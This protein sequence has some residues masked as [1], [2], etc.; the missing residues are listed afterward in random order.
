MHPA[1]FKLFWIRNR[2][3]FRRAIRGARTLRGAVLLLV[4]LGVVGLWVGMTLFMTL[5]LLRQPEAAQVTARY[6]GSAEPYL[7]LILLWLCLTN[8]LQSSG[9]VFLH[10]SP[11]EVEF[12]FPGPFHRRELL[13]FKL[14][15][16]GLGMVLSSLFLASSPMWLYLKTWLGAFVGVALA[17]AMV[18]M[19]GIATGLLGQI[20]AEAAYSKTRKAILMLVMI[21]VATG[22][23]Q[24]FVR[25]RA[26]S[27]AGLAESFRLSWPGRVLLA[28]FEVFSHAILAERLFPDLVGWGAAAAAIDLG[29][30]ILILRLDAD[31]IERAAAISQWIFELQQRARRTGGL[32]VAP[33]RGGTRYRLPQFPWLGGAG[34]IAWRQ[35][36]SILRT[37]SRWIIMSTLGVVVLLLWIEYQTRQSGVT[38]HLPGAGLGIL[39][40][41]TF[42]WA[43][44]PWAFCGDVDHLDFLKTL[45]VRPLA[46]SVGELAGG[47]LVLWAFQL[48]V[49]AFLAAAAP[50]PTRSGN[51][52]S[53]RIA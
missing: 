7:P 35:L 25:T 31:Y 23:P 12:L 21:L 37:S 34:P 26:L 27:A 14:M 53:A 51:N 50:Q 41:A 16:A 49:L 45:P 38:S 32:A 9:G 22:L 19:V 33:T 30:L 24:A 39:S 10:F 6:A 2:A 42:F 40:Y 46:L 29:L 3:A 5:F 15:G 43:L 4:G 47:V 11:P 48:V 36:L 44:A 13:L 18:R 17:M 1:L 52:R 8:L 28:P 20:V